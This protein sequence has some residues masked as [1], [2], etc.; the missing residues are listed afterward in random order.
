MAINNRIII[1][2]VWIGIAVQKDRP[3]GVVGSRKGMVQ[4]KRIVCGLDNRI[5]DSGSRNRQPGNNIGIGC[6]QSGPVDGE[7]FGGIGLLARLCRR[8]RFALQ[9]LFEIFGLFGNLMI[10]TPYSV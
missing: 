9:I 10:F 7:I 6:L 8:G 2:E 4:V 5:G 3:K 1:H